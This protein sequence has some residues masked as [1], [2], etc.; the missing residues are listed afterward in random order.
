MCV[1]CQ[2]P[3]REDRRRRR[4]VALTCAPIFD[5]PQGIVRVLGQA[6]GHLFDHTSRLKETQEVMRGVG[7]R[8]EVLTTAVKNSKNA[9][10]C[11]HSCPRP[12]CF[13]LFRGRHDAR[14]ERGPRPDAQDET[15]R[16]MKIIRNDAMSWPRSAGSRRTH[17]ST[18]THTAGSHR[19]V[20]KCS[21]KLLAPPHEWPQKRNIQKRRTLPSN[22]FLWFNSKLLTFF[23]FPFFFLCCGFTRRARLG[24]GA[25]VGE[26]GG[27]SRIS[28]TGSRWR[29]RARGLCTLAQI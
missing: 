22:R 28:R 4:N 15:T 17:A 23:F 25:R 16:P 21:S 27:D 10:R 20:E 11:S 2:P 19:N 9:S 14:C 12:Q 18:S 5:T 3:C 24:L 6:L 26:H 1:G 7:C 13:F 8:V 29:N